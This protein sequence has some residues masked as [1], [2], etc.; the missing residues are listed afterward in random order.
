[1]ILKFLTELKVL[2]PVS[3]ILKEAHMKLHVALSHFVV[4]PYRRTK[5]LAN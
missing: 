5:G 2:R 4:S 3:R 1:M